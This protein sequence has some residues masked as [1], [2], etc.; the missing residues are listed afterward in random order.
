MKQVLQRMAEYNA[1]A[2][3]AMLAVIAKAPAGLQSKDVGV[4]FKS[5]DGIVEHMAWAI[6]LWLKRF[7]GFGTYPCLA[8]SVLVTRPLDETKAAITGDSAK[9]AALLLEASALLGR[10]IAELPESELERRVKYRTTDGHEMERTYWHT[11]FQVLGHGTHH[12]GEVSAILDQNGVANDFNN[13]VTY[14]P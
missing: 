10:F 6:V 2:G 14:M 4:Y 3:E 13:F 11:I 8:S 12:R 1:K 5:V 9:T 7:A